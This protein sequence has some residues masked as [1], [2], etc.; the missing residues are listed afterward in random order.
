MVKMRETPCPRDG[1]PYPGF[2]VCLDLSNPIYRKV[3]DGLTRDSEGMIVPRS[4]PQTA[5]HR[6]KI[7]HAL[8]QKAAIDPKRIERNK[9]IIRLYSDERLSM[10]KVAERMKINPR[11]VSTVLRIAAS[12]D[13]VIIRRYN[14]R[15]DV[16]DVVAA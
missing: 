4:A 12:Q 7:G 6:E 8:R 11:T 16:D 2:H 3:E 10:A 5:S 14:Q 15:S 9:E 13:L 1:W